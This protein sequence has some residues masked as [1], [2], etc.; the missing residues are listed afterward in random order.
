LGGLDSTLTRS[1]ATSLHKG[2]RLNRLA[3]IVCVLAAAPA[4]A[5]PIGSPPAYPVFDTRSDSRFGDAKIAIQTYLSALGVAKRKKN[6]VCIVG[7]TLGDGTR[8]AWAH[9][10]ERGRIILWEGS[11]NPEDMKDG[12]RLSRL[13]LDLDKDVVADTSA[14]GGSSFLVTRA[15]VSSVLFDCV[16]FGHLYK[17]KVR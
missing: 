3:G 11:S 7:Y 16:R 1:F 12:L 6:H 2:A 10:Q 4:V 9:W 15:W 5:Q 14:V 13:D 8:Q 17:V